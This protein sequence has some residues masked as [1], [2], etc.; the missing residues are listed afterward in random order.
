[1]ESFV[2]IRKRWTGTV[3]SLSGEYLKYVHW[4]DFVRVAMAALKLKNNLAHLDTI[5][6]AL[7]TCASRVHLSSWPLFSKIN[8]F[9]S[10]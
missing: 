8:A 1:M 5:E 9:A 6:R 4:H 3:P 2:E 7:V 10:P